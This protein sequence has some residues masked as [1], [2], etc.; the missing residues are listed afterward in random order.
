[1]AGG[2]FANDVKMH[3]VPDEAREWWWLYVAA[4]LSLLTTCTLPYV[5]E[6]AVYT[7]TSLEMWLNHDFF[8]TTLY[9]TNYGRPP[10]LN[11]LMIPLA[12]VTG[13]D[14]V[15]LAS[16]LITALAT[17]TTGLVLAWLALNLTRNRA[18]AAFSAVVFLSGD[19]LFYR[20]WLAYADPLFTLFVFS[21]I[22]C[23]WIGASRGR[24]LLTWC[25]VA[26][27]TAGF[28][29][30]VQTAYVFYG[31]AFAALLLE[32]DTRRFLLGTNSLLA[33]GAALA[34]LLAWNAWFTHGQ[35][36]SG[37]VVD[38]ALKLKSLD[39]VGYVDQ[40]WS[41]PLETLLRFMPASLVA[42]YYVW[43][44]RP[45]S[46][47]GGA[48]IALPWRVLVAMIVVN[49]L[50]YWLGPGTHIRY[51]MPLYPLVSL[52]IAG[53]IWR[54]GQRP[55]RV[56]AAWL[57]AAIVLRYAVGLW[58]FPWYQEHYRGNYAAV[59]AEIEQATRGFP[60]YATDVS[61]TGLSVTAH[62]DAARY[63]QPYLHWPPEQWSDGF[64]L[65]Y[66]PDPKLGWTH[67]RYT[68]G[69]NDLY[70]LCRGTACNSGAAKP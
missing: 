11:W 69:A 53:L 44:T 70:L 51:I 64:V 59:A 14:H 27:L 43:R 8:V 17:A 54:V 61:S 37:T 63:P 30:K 18:F 12:E 4:A 15:L 31:V 48:P 47:A 7:I 24:H 6:E 25:A 35:Q 26:L 1:L 21:A 52:F 19:A 13:W 66:T 42:I 60:L 34:A 9:G 20:G 67:T 38:I 40:L 45:D 46:S 33:H 57:V 65:S 41:F 36:A 68:L 39:I 56:A 29:T 28:L 22:A 62:L 49:Y 3:F 23:L 16:R 10:L 5:G 58:G 32:R 55:V 50:P 2:V